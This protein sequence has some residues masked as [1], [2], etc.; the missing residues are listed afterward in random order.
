V[1]TAPAFSAFSAIAQMRSSDRHKLFLG[2]EIGD[3]AF[4]KSAKKRQKAPF[5]RMSK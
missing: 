3:E 5:R 1:R 2:I 4:P